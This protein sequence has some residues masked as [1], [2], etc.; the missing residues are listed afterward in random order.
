MFLETASLIVSIICPIVTIVLAFIFRDRDRGK[1][2]QSSIQP[3]ISHS[4]VNTGLINGNLQYQDNSITKV[5]QTTIHQN[6]YHSSSGAKDSSTLV[7]SA[8]ACIIL[9]A[10]AAIACFTKVSQYIPFSL[11]ILS[12]VV[13]TVCVI[14]IV[15]QVPD[16]TSH[17]YIPTLLLTGNALLVA[18]FPYHL[19]LKPANTWINFQPLLA[20]SG[21]AAFAASE[22]IF[23]YF[24]VLRFARRRCS[25]KHREEL[26]CL[27]LAFFGI[28]LSTF[29]FRLIS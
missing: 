15:K 19:N 24:S 4:V 12:L 22:L 23:S 3:S 16:F 21:F 27:A 29:L 20:L 11:A 9:V 13:L 1:T 6:T 28:C 26:L 5:Q 17:L 18:L 7:G 10:L 8:I 2:Q 14:G 25:K